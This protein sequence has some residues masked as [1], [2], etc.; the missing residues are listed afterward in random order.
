MDSIGKHFLSLVRK[1]TTK[2]EL[3]GQHGMGHEILLN[4]YAA[5]TRR[6]QIDTFLNLYSSI[7]KKRNA[8]RYGSSKILMPSATRA[9]SSMPPEPSLMST[10]ASSQTCCRRST[11]AG[12]RWSPRVTAF[13]FSRTLPDKAD[14]ASG[15]QT[16]L[17]PCPGRLALPRR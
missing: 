8:A 3:D 9:A 1:T 17:P 13:C 14:L 4:V 5:V 11:P 2:D 6:W 15:V 16:C 10:K 7:M 12:G